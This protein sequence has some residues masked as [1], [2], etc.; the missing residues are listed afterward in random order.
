MR[1]RLEQDG[2]GDW[3]SPS[4]AE[5]RDGRHYAEAVLLTLSILK[6][7]EFAEST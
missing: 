3:G 6:G 1:V 2:L 4:R 5:K 7:E